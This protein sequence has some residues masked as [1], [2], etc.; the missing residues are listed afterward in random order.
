MKILFSR[1]GESQANLLRVISNRG[2]P[3]YLT[4]AGEEQSRALAEAL[5]AFEVNQI[6]CSP[7]PRAR[8]TAAIVAAR[9]GLSVTEA[10]A[11]GEFD[12]GGME[13][14]GDEVAWAAHRA[15]TRAW[16]EDH[17]YNRRI[18]PDG[19]SFNDMRARFLPFISVLDPRGG[20]ILLISHG[21]VLFQ[22]LPLVLAN[23]DRNFTRAHS[24]GYCGLIVTQ[25]VEGHLVC[26]RWDGLV[27]QTKT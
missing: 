5:S 22:M 9:L 2:L 13:G 3:H 8:Q 15:V 17:D 27:Y 26:E 25:P 7:I 24:L 12:C 10:S 11:L 19:E 18:P 1:H 20:D 21:A 4:P 16:D 6:Y 14:R 23:V